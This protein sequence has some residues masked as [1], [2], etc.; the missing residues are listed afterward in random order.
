[1]TNILVTNTYRLDAVLQDPNTK[2]TPRFY[3]KN[4]T[5]KNICM[6]YDS[7]LSGPHVRWANTEFPCMRWWVPKG[8]STPH[9]IKPRGK[10]FMGMSGADPPQCHVFSQEIAGLFKGLWNPSL[11]L[12]VRH[13]FCAFAVGFTKRKK[14]RQRQNSTTFIARCDLFVRISRFFL[15]SVFSMDHSASVNRWYLVSPS[16]RQYVPDI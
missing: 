11:S 10:P 12:K 16:R 8:I 13:I 15:L 1:M 7:R 9:I 14:R 2:K 5:T 4:N 3:P 6:Q